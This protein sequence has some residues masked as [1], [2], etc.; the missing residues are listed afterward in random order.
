M[1]W[2]ISHGTPTGGPTHR[3]YNGVERVA[4][5]L[6]HALTT[7]DWALLKPVFARRSG[8]PFEIS[9]DGA[10]TIAALLTRAADSGLMTPDTAQAARELATAATRA[11]DARHLWTWS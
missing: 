10:R 7:R 5:S 6:S 9:P 11:A 2:T 1:G 4:Q 8:D 3:S